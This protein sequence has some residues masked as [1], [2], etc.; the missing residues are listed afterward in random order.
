[1]VTDSLGGEAL[2][3]YILSVFVF[4]FSFFG[5]GLISPGLNLAASAT[6]V[7]RM[8]PLQACVTE[9]CGPLKN[10]EQL[11]GAGDFGK[12]L[13]ADVSDLLST[14]INP[15]FKS[16]MAGDLALTTAGLGLWDQASSLLD[17]A[18]L[19][20]DQ[21]VLLALAMIFQ[22]DWDATISSWDTVNDFPSHIERTKLYH[23]FPGLNPDVLSWAATIMESA[24]KSNSFIASNEIDGAS[25]ANMLRILRLKGSDVQAFAEDI[26][27]MAQN[28]NTRF[29]ALIIAESDWAIARKVVA[30][31]DLLPFEENLYVAFVARVLRLDIFLKSE[32][33]DLILSKPV[34]FALAR[35]SMDIRIQKIRSALST[36]S[37]QDGLENSMLDICDAN[38]NAYLAGAPSSLGKQNFKTLA[39][40]VR[41]TA[42]STLSE[43]LSG[44]GLVSATAALD[45]AHFQLPPD[46]VE[47]KRDLTQI[48]NAT[49]ED[50]RS[51][52]R[53]ST[54]LHNRDEQ[55]SLLL[56]FLVGLGEDPRP[57]IFSR[58]QQ[59]CANIKPSE[60]ADKTL[61][62]YGEIV[63]SWQSAV[64]PQYGAGI[65]AH[66][67][68]HV[69]TAALNAPQDLSLVRTCDYIR[70]QQFYG[71]SASIPGLNDEEDWADRFSASVMKR[72]AP[73]WPSAANMAC[74]L[75]TTD[76]QSLAEGSF[77]LSQDSSNSHSTNIYRLLQVQKDLTGTLPPSCRSVPGLVSK[78]TV[79]CGK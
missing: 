18:K 20:D 73:N 53:K 78:M 77:D 42:R 31:E 58:T 17:P 63:V 41:Q 32:T 15:D 23:L 44:G 59:V 64:W 65:L 30:G 4:P 16:M 39:E 69:V 37:K 12:L 50:I 3:K 22:I 46:R 67:L 56:F 7:D 13:T 40:K 47:V 75:M 14:K 51:R 76:R 2:S 38:A 60:F 36:P 49:T 55:I 48:L 29:G 8:N 54:L 28:I 68:G 25:F 57:A 71:A 19:T 70:H 66:E 79:R 5:F 35:A 27:W 24:I 9:I 10:L 1:M 33:R 6:V 21:T 61:N 72:L 11:S 26:V 34:P 45:A 74:I 43:F 62:R 52:V